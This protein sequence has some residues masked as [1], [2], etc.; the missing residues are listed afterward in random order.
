MPLDHPAVLVASPDETPDRGHHT[1]GATRRRTPG[2]GQKVWVAPVAV[3]AAAL[4]L[5]LL[6]AAAGPTDWDSAQYVLATGQYDVTH[7]LPQPPGYWLYVEC[8]RALA[9]LSGLGTV[10]ALVL[11]AA[12]AS[13]LAAGLTVVAGRDLGG[14]W[15]GMAAGLVIATSPFAWFSGSVVATYS[16]DLLAG[17]LLMVLAW[18]ARPGSWHGVAAVA[19]V[20]ILVGFRQSI[21]QSFALLALVPVIAATRTWRLLA[22]TVGAGLA[23]VC[24]WFVP[25]VATQPGG[26]A[27]WAHATRLEA[28]GAAQSTSVLDHAPGGATNLGTFAGY[29]TVAL[30]PLALMA[31][32]GLVVFGVR[33]LVAARSPSSSEAEAGPVDAGG[34]GAAGAAGGAERRPWYQSR[35]AIFGGALLPPMLLVSLVQFAKGG[36]LLAYLPAAIILLLLPLGAL[37]GT[38]PRSDRARHESVPSRRISLP[39]LAVSTIAV[40]LVVVLGAQRFLG[41]D[42]VL[43]ASWVRSSGAL[44]LVQPR[45]QAPYADTRAAIVAADEIDAALPGLAPLVR[46][47]RDVVVFDTVDGGASIYRNAGWALPSDRVA[48]VAPGVV[49][50]NELHGALYY[51]SGAT[52]SVGPAGSVLLV[53][54][55]ALPGLA[56]LA[57]AGDARPVATPRP[58][59]DYRVFKIPPGTSLLGV[60]VVATSGPRP[61]GTGIS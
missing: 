7:G 37:T 53:A 15:V 61:L 3:G 50:Y 36:Y 23:S 39:W 18:R 10:H 12:L 54:S 40:A 21:V 57:A 51:A 6:T 11:L 31:I 47:S 20:G 49:Q 35:T 58:I 26:F 43:P 4:V 60:G 29:T 32:L 25:M 33:S 27:A 38:L 48:L 56:S 46:S 45:Y 8:G 17:P 42:G 2:L 44:W 28:T 41:G 30:A 14:P 22:A 9:H 16:F 55:P 52:L 24:I 5:R 13:G 34:V 59:G 1:S 19:A